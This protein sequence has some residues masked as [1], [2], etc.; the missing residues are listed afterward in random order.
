LNSFK[1][2]IALT[3]S[4]RRPCPAVVL[5][6]AMSHLILSGPRKNKKGSATRFHFHND[7]TRKSPF[8]FVGRPISSLIFF[9]SVLCHDLKSCPLYARAGDSFF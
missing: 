5:I 9:R 4:I 2:A 3:D 6:S 1:I 8:G 7:R